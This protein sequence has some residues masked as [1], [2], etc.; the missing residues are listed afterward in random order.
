ML[1]ITTS[2]S[3]EIFSHINIDDFKDPELTKQWV[4]FFC[5]FFDAPCTSRVNCDEIDGD[6]LRQFA[7]RNCYRLSRV[8]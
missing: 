8:S 6:E 3:D 2:T 4:L 1:P 7:N 5:I